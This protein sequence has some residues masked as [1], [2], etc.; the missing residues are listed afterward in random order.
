[1]LGSQAGTGHVCKCRIKSLCKT[2][3]VRYRLQNAAAA[4]AAAAT[5]PHLRHRD[6][7]FVSQAN[8]LIKSKQQVKGGGRNLQTRRAAIGVA[9]CHQLSGSKTEADGRST[10]HVLA[11]KEQRSHYAWTCLW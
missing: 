3:S 7:L 10:L 8:D 6:I 1:M 2:A 5:L 9:L 11:C 4:A